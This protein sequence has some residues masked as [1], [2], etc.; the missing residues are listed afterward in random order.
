LRCHRWVRPPLA[1]AIPQVTR[2]VVSPPRGRQDRSNVCGRRRMAGRGLSGRQQG[3]SHLS[4]E[5][6]ARIRAGAIAPAASPR[7]SAGECFRKELECNVT[8]QLQ[9]FRLI[10]YSHS[11]ATNLAEDAVMGNRLPHGFRGNGHWPECQVEWSA[12]VNYTPRHAR[13]RIPK[14]RLLQLGVLRLGLL[15]D[16]RVGS[17][18]TAPASQEHISPG[19]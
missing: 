5:G 2:R 9:V 10:D 15:G 1:S 8:T 19:C 18:L 14:I 16:V 11:P 3:R 7:P 4:A 17:A 13:P 6:L 12:E